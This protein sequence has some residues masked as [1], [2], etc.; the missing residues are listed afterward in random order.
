MALNPGSKEHPDKSSLLQELQHK[1]D[2]KEPIEAKASLRKPESK[3]EKKRLRRCS[4]SSSVRPSRSSALSREAPHRKGVVSGLDCSARNSPGRLLRTTLENMQIHLRPGTPLRGDEPLVTQ[5]LRQVL[6]ALAKGRNARELRHRAAAADEVLK[7]HLEQGLEILLQRFKSRG[8][9]LARGRTL[10]PSPAASRAK[11][12]RRAERSPSPTSRRAG[13]LGREVMS[14]ESV[15]DCTPHPGRRVS[16]EDCPANV[17]S[18]P[19]RNAHRKRGAR[20][21]RR[22]GG[23]RKL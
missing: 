1:P 19:M 10:S 15:V 5:R 11:Q 3:N 20:C 17:D 16:F 13:R 12:R 18:P 21:G 4:S 6:G 9:A 14:V 8:T 23:A 2:D 22:R 7:G